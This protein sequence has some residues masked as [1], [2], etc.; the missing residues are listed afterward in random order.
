MTPI[1][2]AIFVG[3]G[4][5]LGTLYFVLVHRTARLLAVGASASRIVPLYVARLALAVAVL[6]VIAQ[7]GA[8][9]LLLALLGFVV[10]RMVVQ[11]RLGAR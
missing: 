4:A 9:P 10:A 7:H 3:A 8:M 5:A 11:Y 6:W 1:E 2:L